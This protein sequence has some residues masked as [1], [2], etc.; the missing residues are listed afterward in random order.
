MK[1]IVT[2]FIKG[3]VLCYVSNPSNRNLGFYTPFPLPTQPWKSVSMDFGSGFPMSR[4]GHN[5]LYVVVDCFS[6]MCILMPSK[7]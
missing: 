7:K 1:N 2:C 3:C 4:K 6:K 5:Y